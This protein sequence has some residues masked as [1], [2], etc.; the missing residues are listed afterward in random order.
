MVVWHHVR[1]LCGRADLAGDAVQPRTAAHS[2]CDRG[3]HRNRLPAGHVLLQGDGHHAKPLWPRSLCCRHRRGELLEHARRGRL[4]NQFVLDVLHATASA[5]RDR[6]L[7]IRAPR[8]LLVH[9]QGHVL[10]A[11][12]RVRG[13]GALPLFA[14]VGANDDGSEGGAGAKRARRHS[15]QVLLHRQHHPYAAAGLRVGPFKVCWGA[16]RGLHSDGVRP[17]V[18]LLWRRA[19]HVDNLLH[20]VCGNFGWNLVVE[21]VDAAGPWGELAPTARGVRDPQRRPYAAGRHVDCAVAFAVAV[22]WVVEQN[23]AASPMRNV[24]LARQS[25]AVEGTIIFPE[26]RRLLS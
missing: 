21:R 22:R 18:D 3:A 17:R 2:P 16:P 1:L 13:G 9:A 6:R 20:I 12:G 24:Y 8:G 7:R 26:R 10:G 23:D 5:H 15:D 19:A 4:S 11:R 14:S 25:V